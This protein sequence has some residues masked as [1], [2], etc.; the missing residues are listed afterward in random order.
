MDATVCGGKTKQV[1]YFGNEKNFQML[2]MCVVEKGTGN[3][4]ESEEECCVLQY[5]SGSVLVVVLLTVC[6]PV[7]L[8]WQQ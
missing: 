3:G 5:E 2:E 8:V 1:P 6:E 4:I 7:P